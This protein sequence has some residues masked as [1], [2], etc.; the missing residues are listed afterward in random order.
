MGRRGAGECEGGRE[1]QRREIAK[2]SG[3]PRS[4]C[5]RPECRGVAVDRIPFSRCT[6]P[7]YPSPSSLSFLPK[8]YSP[9]RSRLSFSAPAL[10]SN[11]IASTP[12]GQAGTVFPNE[13]AVLSSPAINHLLPPI[14]KNQLTTTRFPDI[15]KTPAANLNPPLH[16]P[17]ATGR[18]PTRV[19]LCF[20]SSHHLG[21][22]HASPGSPPLSPIR[23][24][25]AP[26]RRCLATGPLHPWPRAL[27]VHSPS[28]DHRPPES[29][30]GADCARSPPHLFKS[31]PLLD[32]A[33]CAI[34]RAP[35]PTQQ[36]TKHGAWHILLRYE[37]DTLRG[38]RGL[39]S[40]RRRHLALEWTY[41]R[42]HLIT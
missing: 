18:P 32:P 16:L 1:S 6:R 40:A 27:S 33:C 22:P 20:P 28:R 11:H 37:Y 9:F 36:A 10:E 15:H 35:N 31:S 8:P 4:P 19:G 39:V 21:A 14:S 25:A 13:M 24:S 17:P 23:T 26:P 38:L 42:A 2:R 3:D 34:P 29:P 7:I 30:P 5:S 41:W 12:S